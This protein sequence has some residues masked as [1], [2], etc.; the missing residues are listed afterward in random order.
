MKEC[1]GNGIRDEGSKAISESLRIN[2]S[3]TELYL[4]SDEKIRNE[5]EKRKGNEMKN[6]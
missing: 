6:E 1:I 4:G 5:K 2:T 3:L